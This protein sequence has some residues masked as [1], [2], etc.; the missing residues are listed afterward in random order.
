MSLVNDVLRDLEKR[1][2]PERGG[3]H[4]LASNSIVEPH[5]TLNRGLAVLVGLLLAVIAIMGVW[6]FYVFHDSAAPT[7]SDAPRASIAPVSA[8][9]VTPAVS[10]PNVPVTPSLADDAVSQGEGDPPQPGQHLG[11]QTH[12]LANQQVL[13]LAQPT[14]PTKTARLS[15]SAAVQNRASSQAKQASAVTDVSNTG[16]SL[17]P[18]ETGLARDT[19]TE[20]RQLAPAT[21]LAEATDES[22]EAVLPAASAAP[23]VK[24]RVVSAE[25]QDRLAAQRASELL[26]QGLAAQAMR[27]LFTFIEANE[28]DMAARQVL[29]TQLLQ[30]GRLA[31]AG[32]YILGAGDLSAAPAMREL[33]ARWLDAR[34][35]TFSA[36]QV[37]NAARPDIASHA[38]YYSLLAAYSQKQAMYQQSAEIYA[39]LLNV[40]AQR[41]GWWAGLAIASEYLGQAQQ[42]KEAYQRAL[43]LSDLDRQLETFV[44]KRLLALA[45]T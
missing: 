41:A 12:K 15:D 5:S 16:S 43:A 4:G 13:P 33:K 30:E 14:S 24:Q 36:I 39:A 19:Q 18:A 35:E 40:D 7:V 3:P 32:D 10:S 38:T 6:F 2:A 45:G 27:H 1:Q 9:A 11:T 26:A 21:S 31:Q 29:V 8:E 17:A 28:A 37:L 44:S 34:G 25:E 22:A 42:A 23:S 20:S